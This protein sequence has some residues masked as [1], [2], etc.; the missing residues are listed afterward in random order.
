MRIV[1][2]EISLSLVFRCLVI[3]L[4]TSLQPLAAYAVTANVTWVKSFAAAGA[5]SFVNATAVDSAGNT[6]I[7]GT[8]AS[9]TLTV[10]STTL[11]RIGSQDGYIAKLDSSGSV[12]WA[13]NIGGSGAFTTLWAMT[14]DTASTP[15]LYIAG[16]FSGG[17]LPAIGVT[18]IGTQDAL[19]IKL[20]S[21]GGM[22]T[23]VQN[24]GGTGATFYFND[25]AIDNAAT[26]NV[27]LAGKFSGADLT[28]PSLAKQGTQDAI[29]MKLP[30]NTGTPNA[31]AQSFGDTGVSMSFDGVCISV[32]N[33]AVA[34]AYAI[35][36]FSGANLPSLGYT[37]IGAADGIAMQ[38]DT[39]SGNS[40][41]GHR[42]AGTSVSVNLNRCVAD[43]ASA[44]AQ[45]GVYVVGSF[46]GGDI[47]TPS[48]LTN[49]GSQDGLA[50]KLAADTGNTTWIQNFG[51]S[52]SYLSF[53]GVQIDTATTPN[54]YIAGNSAGTLTVPSLAPISAQQDAFLMRLPSTGGTTPGWVRNFGGPNT[55]Q[56]NFRAVAIDSATTP[57]VSVGGYLK[58][59]DWTSPAVTFVGTS[60][61][62]N[63][64]SMKLAQISLPGAPTGVSATAGD[65]QASV[66]F[67]APASDGNATITSY[68]VT[69]SPGGATASGSSSPITV[70]GL[71]NGTS[72]TFT[73]TATNAAG[74]GSSSTA[75]SAITPSAPVTTTSPPPPP[76][77]G[78]TTGVVPITV[79]VTPPAT[80]GTSNL[81]SG[82]T[83][84]IATAKLPANIFTNTSGPLTFTLAAPVSTGSTTP[85]SSATAG[86]I[87]INVPAATP[88]GAAGATGSTSNVSVAFNIDTRTFTFVSP[89]IIR[90]GSRSTVRAKSADHII[91]GADSGVPTAPVYQV[92]APAVLAI[93]TSLTLTGTDASGNSGSVTI[94]ITLYAPTEI[95]DLV[96]ASSDLYGALGQGNSTAPVLSRD[97]Q[98]LS[99]TTTAANLIGQGAGSGAQVMRYATALGSVDLASQATSISGSFNGIAVSGAALNPTLS[100]DGSQL[101]FASDAANIFPYSIFTPVST[102]QIYALTGNGAYSFLTPSPQPVTA[103]V[104]V[105]LAYTFDRPA[106]S[107]DGTKI[108]FESN[109]PLTGAP[110]GLTQIYVKT[111]ATGAVSLV[112]ATSTGI[113][114]TGSSAKPSISDDGRYILF[115]SDAGNFPGANSQR[116]VFLKDTASGSLTLVSAATNGL[117]ANAPAMNGKLSGAVNDGGG[118]LFAAFESSASN[119]GGGLTGASQVYVRDF[120]VGQTKLVSKNASGTAIGGSVPCISGDGRFVVYR[121]TG[122]LTSN[123]AASAAQ[124]YVA[125]IFAGTA[126]L[127]STDANG[128][129][130]NDAS[131][132]P[133]ISGDGRTIAFASLATNLDGTQTNGASQI[134]LA[135]NPLKP[136]LANGYW[137]NPVVPGQ[138]VLVEQAG[139]LI[140]LSNLAMAADTS[141]LWNF[142]SM[143]SLVSGTY[144][145]SLIQPS[146]GGILGSS[147][148]AAITAVNLGTAGLTPI[149]QMAANFTLAGNPQAIQRY[150]FVGGGA[151][152]GQAIGYPETGWWYVP[153][154]GQ[155]LFLEAQGGNLLVSV[156]AYSQAGQATWYQAY[157]TIALDTGFSG[158][159]TGCATATL[160]CQS[161]AGAIS[162][163][164]STPLAGTMTLGTGPALAIRRFRF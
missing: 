37:K 55:A 44:G 117:G 58:N 17:S 130:G 42:V 51:G 7:A 41:W 36:S 15:N 152:T 48:S 54:L 85:T 132:A 137:V 43:G 113:A 136:P 67:S 86:T 125:D 60:G 24:F 19:A 99:F 31:F 46:S 133:A 79:T 142:A 116:Q 64:L 131:D 121:S 18:K 128:L 2:S 28:T 66:S 149:S 70:T 59:A 151:S 135:A 97:G 11:T 50:F 114:G 124:I 107:G 71:N 13:Q 10:G 98:V 148:L 80:S 12:V 156:L 109:A 103:K 4:V 49:I 95:G 68:S 162:L 73:V 112:S 108:A 22:P 164:F 104:Y 38:F 26:P 35:G 101:A 77:V 96:A 72:Y 153:A 88:K 150:S 83:N 9:A 8:F 30:G 105:P 76:F 47:S 33:S 138:F 57:N 39:S 16:Y 45:Q 23:W 14:I 90:T 141:R 3:A 146:G 118:R 147:N 122:S 158:R 111:I 21:T 20:P 92:T 29:L 126:A 63:A 32:N 154:N 144:Q 93:S 78:T 140:W 120:T 87:S 27:Y 115:E 155:S 163:A 74:T 91:Q 61:A 34:T 5:N 84:G 81:P 1:K 69:A 52:T 123:T 139:D 110:S 157:G 6:Y 161:D 119:L 129:P 25:I 94:P 127:V 159:L 75:S 62:Y 143:S 102:R 106:L 40:G 134:Y 89:P 65:G 100:A 56:G 82:V 53:L 145:G 160:L